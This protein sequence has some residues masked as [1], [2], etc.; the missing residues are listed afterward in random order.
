[1]TLQGSDH[2]LSAV[3]PP[4]L[5][6]ASSEPYFS[7]APTV[8]KSVEEEPAL[9]VF[10]DSIQFENGFGVV[11][12]SSKI[13]AET[14]KIISTRMFL[15]DAVSFVSATA[16]PTFSC[17]LSGLD[18]LLK[19]LSSLM[20]VGMKQGSLYLVFLPE[21]IVYAFQIAAFFVSYHAMRIQDMDTYYK[22][23]G[24]NVTCFILMFLVLFNKRPPL[25]LCRRAPRPGEPSKLVQYADLFYHVVMMVLIFIA[26]IT[27]GVCT[28]CDG[29]YSPSLTNLCQYNSRSQGF[30]DEYVNT[31]VS[32]SS[33]TYVCD[34]DRKDACIGG[35]ITNL[36]VIIL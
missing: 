29:S 20:G 2:E 35:V 5:D 22:A 36:L 15:V 1:M 7:Q 8:E 27:S 10:L 17:G 32:P 28:H 18:L 25:Q 30:H 23:T 13:P 33:C 16:G 26:L 9:S 19:Y 12:I 3:S 4:P 31:R 34:S 6:P 11:K 14:A 24:L 21:H